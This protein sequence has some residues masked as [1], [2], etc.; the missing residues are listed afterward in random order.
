[1]RNINQLMTRAVRVDRRLWR[2]DVRNF[3]HQRLAFGQVSGTREMAMRVAEARAERLSDGVTK[4]FRV[5][6]KG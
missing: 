5:D 6:R 4:C 3:F 2:W 1:M